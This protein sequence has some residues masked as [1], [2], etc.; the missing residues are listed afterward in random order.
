MSDIVERLKSVELA[1]VEDELIV[2]EAIDE[3][4]RLQS[5]LDRADEWRK[6]HLYDEPC[7]CAYD[8][9]DDWCLG[10][11]PRLRELLFVRAEVERLRAALLRQ[12]N[13]ANHEIDRLRALLEAAEM[14]F[15]AANMHGAAA[16]I[17]SE[18]GG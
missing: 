4:R 18:L 3:I 10:H 14:T 7:G 15:R 8:T 9:P 11:L 17:K 2:G 13:A 16:S 5:A 1:D 12:T 6:E